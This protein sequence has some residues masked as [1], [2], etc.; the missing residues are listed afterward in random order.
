MMSLHY[1]MSILGVIASTAAI[2]Q[3]HANA[4]EEPIEWSII[5][6]DLP[7]Q[8]DIGSSHQITYQL[9]SNLPFE[10]PTPFFI[11]KNHSSDAFTYTDSCHGVQLP[12]NGTCTIIIDFNPIGGGNGHVGLTVEYGNTTI[13]LPILTTTT[14]Q[15]WVGA[16]GVDYNPNHYLNANP[17]N[18]HDVFYV[19]SNGSQAVSNIYMELSQLQAAG[20]NIVRSYQT[21]EYSW[22]DL[23]NQAT[24]LG[25]YVVYEA[26]IPQ[27]GSQADITNAISV[28]NNVINAVGVSTFQKTVVLVFAGHENYSNTDIN[29]LTS[30]ISQLQATLTGASLVIPVSSALVSGDLVT[31]GSPADMQ[32]LINSYSAAAPLGFDPYPFQWGVTPPDQ[33]ASNASLQNSIAWDYAQVEAQSF[34]VSPRAILMAETGWATDGTGQFADYYCY[35]QG[36]CEPSV[37]NAATY[38]TALY[39][40]V[41]TP[42]NNSGA[43]VFEAYDEPAKDPVNST[44]AE[45]Y[46]GVFDSNC[47]LKDNNVNLLPNTA[48]VPGSNYGCQGFTRGALFTV[49]GLNL[50][51]QAPF[52][53]AVS[54]TNPV[55]SQAASMS[56]N[57]PNINRTN[58]N[59]NPWPQYLAYNGATITL[60]GTSGTVCTVTATVIPANPPSIPFPVL[61]FANAPSCTN[62]AYQVN[63]AS[64]VCYLP[65]GF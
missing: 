40:F 13:P 8:T 7:T 10:M 27:N 15:N 14:A 25:M 1:Y 53:V 60:T 63:C 58:Q 9:V 6:G 19:G 39:A 62:P 17:F 55:T 37:S 54:Q 47:N 48:Y 5:T 21:V 65:T 33:A 2:A 26:V 44:N 41:N 30:A 28:L 45:N 50:A 29:Y 64:N 56:V 49:V 59:V 22:I 24:A 16:I 20:F 52:T 23:I 18:F 35:I 57:V 61:T 12:A 34:Y 38:L 36:D 4:S 31:P 46:Y 42:S 43:L 11:T 3:V 51:A 32:T